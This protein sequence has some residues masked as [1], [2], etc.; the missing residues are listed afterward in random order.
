MRSRNIYWIKIAV[1]ANVSWKIYPTIA[2]TCRRRLLDRPL[3]RRSEKQTN[4]QRHIIIFARKHARSISSFLQ[5]RAISF[6]RVWKLN[7]KTRPWSVQYYKYLCI[8]FY[9]YNITVVLVNDRIL[10]P[11]PFW[12]FRYRIIVN[13][14]RRRDKSTTNIKYPYCWLF[15]IETHNLMVFQESQCKHFNKVTV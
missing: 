6:P 9:Y 4:Q 1:V 15:F 14:K 8:M 3:D 2:V 5:C 12:F 10:M 13:S 11:T 7:L